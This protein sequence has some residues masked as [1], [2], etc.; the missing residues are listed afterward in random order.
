[1]MIRD[2]IFGTFS[3]REKPAVGPSSTLAKC[4][5]DVPSGEKFDQVMSQS[6]S[7]VKNGGRLPSPW[8]RPLEILCVYSLLVRQTEPG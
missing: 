5:D 7:V 1:L 8:L 3:W 4:S 6:W 2:L